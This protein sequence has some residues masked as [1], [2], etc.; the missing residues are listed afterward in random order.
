MSDSMTALLGGKKAVAKFRDGMNSEVTVRQLP[1]RLMPDYL[2]LIDDEPA[3]LE[4]VCALKPEE[5]DRLTPQSHDELVALVE[6]VNGEGFFAWLR[7]RVE[8]QER[9]APGSS[10][11]LGKALLSASP[12]GSRNARSDAA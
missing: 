3:R 10:G 1:V 7:R 9:L 8:R 6:E 11:E 5:V 4:L 2:R 12:T